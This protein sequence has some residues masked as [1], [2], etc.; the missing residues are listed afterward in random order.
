M[1]RQF[2]TR[3]NT[4]RDVKSTSTSKVHTDP[5]GGKYV[6]RTD[7][8][9]CKI[10]KS[11]V[12]RENWIKGG[13]FQT[14]DTFTPEAKNIWCTIPGD[15]QIKILNTVW[16]TRC[17]SLAGITEITAKVDSGMLVLT[18][19]CTRCGGDVARVIG[20]E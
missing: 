3:C 2:C 15:A 8:F 18:G 4:I 14:E 10:C 6:I 20:S 5:D 19:K 16:C 13:M 11:F 7:L 12:R 17:R 9:H 1:K